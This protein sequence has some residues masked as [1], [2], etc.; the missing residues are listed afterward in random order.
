MSE[1]KANNWEKR[2]QNRIEAAGVANPA[3]VVRRLTDAQE[4]SVIA[5]ARKIN[6]LERRLK[7]Q[8]PNAWSA[9]SQL[10]APRDRDTMQ[11]EAI[12]A[13]LTEVRDRLVD[14]EARSVSAG[15]RSLIVLSQELVQGREATV[16]KLAGL[17]Q[18]LSDIKTD[19]ATTAQHWGGH[20]PWQSIAFGIAAA[21]A[22]VV[23]AATFAYLMKGG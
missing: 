3:D 19:L 1:P 2:L 21:L 16:S 18:H 23:L 5:A 12:L 22:T 17:D 15:S 9:S 14:A 4:T 7:G 6:A 10:D 8:E 11:H 20:T 13:R